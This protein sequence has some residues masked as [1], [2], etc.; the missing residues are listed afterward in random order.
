MQTNENVEI[1]FENQNGCVRIITGKHDGPHILGEPYRKL[2]T[3][4]YTIQIRHQKSDSSYSS[5][6]E[7]DK[8]YMSQRTTCYKHF[9]AAVNALNNGTKIRRYTG[10]DDIRYGH[11]VAESWKHE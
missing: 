3:K 9:F 1:E 2:G 7:I 6:A 5:W 11:Q 10:I 4:T 8:Y